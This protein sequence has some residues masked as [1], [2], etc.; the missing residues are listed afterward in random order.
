MVSGLWNCFQ[1]TGEYI[2]RPGQGHTRYT[3]V[4][5]DCYILQI[6][7]LHHHESPRALHIDLRQAPAVCISDQTVRNRLQEENLRSRR[8][9][10]GPVFT[11]QQSAKQPDLSSP[12]I[13]KISSCVTGVLYSSQMSRAFTCP[14]VT[15]VQGCGN[16]LESVTPS[17][18]SWNT[19]DMEVGP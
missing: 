14:R 2:R 8:P 3:T 17:A 18:I 4:R 6:A 7:L 11:G 16:G 12:E 5:Q 9:V 13:T 15:D 10:P 1:T 19:I